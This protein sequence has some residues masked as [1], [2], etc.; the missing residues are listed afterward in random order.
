MW[1]LRLVFMLAVLAFSGSAM[2][3]SRAQA[4]AGIAAYQSGKATLAKGDLEA[5]YMLFWEADALYPGALPKYW[6]ARCLDDL[7]QRQEAV[8]AYK[9]FLDSKPPAKHR[10]LIAQAEQRLSA[11][12]Q[13]KAK[14]TP[15]AKR[16]PEPTAK[17]K[18]P[19]VVE[20]NEEASKDPREQDDRTAMKVVGFTFLAA[21][22]GSGAALIAS[23]ERAHNA[24][25]PS[26]REA[27]ATAT[28]ALVPVTV[29]T[30]LT[31]AVLL[32]LSFAG[33]TEEAGEPKA[34]LQVGATGAAV[35]V[36]F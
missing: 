16:A 28:Q 25:S 22:L 13:P 35:T 29:A 17:Q 1:P 15:M 20:P 24:R 11:L 5:A 33:G 3:T 30:L 23:F 8:A 32:P 12:Q 18:A 36:S 10:E 6:Q 26:D 2:A 21:S 27:Y 14:R 31:T 7:G 19:V 34:Q 9:T 4:Q